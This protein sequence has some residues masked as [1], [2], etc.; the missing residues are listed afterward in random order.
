VRL[1]LFRPLALGLLV[2][3][4]LLIAPAEARAA[5]CNP[6]TFT[7]PDGSSCTT[8]ADCGGATDG[9]PDAT[10]DAPP[11]GMTADVGNDPIAPDNAGGQ[12]TPHPVDMPARVDMKHDMQPHDG[13]NGDTADGPP[14]NV[15]YLSCS[16]PT[17]STP[18]GSAGD[19]A[20]HL[21]LAGLA[22]AG[23]CFWSRR[24]RRV[25]R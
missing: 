5:T 20:L 8:D 7:C 18:D 2:T 17:G 12:D 15:G 21:A 16:T 14:P 13:G 9:G 24:H 11:D 1:V 22:V 19:G 3:A 4:A 23:A 6:L 25:R 10:P